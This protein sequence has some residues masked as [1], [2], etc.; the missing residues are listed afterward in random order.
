MKAVGTWKGGF[1]TELEDARGHTVTVDLPAEEDG[2][3][4]GTSALELSVLSLAGCLTTIFALVAKRR[5]LPF[6]AMS[7]DLDAA[8][9]RGARTIVSVEGTFRIVTSAPVE[10][11]RMALDLTLR[12]CPVGVLYEQARIPVRVRPIVL[13]PEPTAA[14]RAE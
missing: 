12:I 2:G 8:R 6:D 7:V 1:Q 13:P 9:P 14:G 10:D 4:L 3:N 11:V 5:K